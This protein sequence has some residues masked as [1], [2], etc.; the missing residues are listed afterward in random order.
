MVAG[1]LNFSI[2]AEG[3]QRGG[4]REAEPP[5]PPSEA[6]C[7]VTMVQARHV[8]WFTVVM[9]S[10]ATQTPGDLRDRRTLTR[11]KEAEKICP[12]LGIQC[13]A[14]SFLRGNSLQKRCCHIT[15]F[16]LWGVYEI[17]NKTHF[18][19][20]LN[21]LHPLGEYCIYYPW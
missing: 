2:V 1:Q 3:E 18:T 21:N 17:S 5:P 12:K 14:Y 10:S 6:P 19:R 9:S 20:F 16:I 15:V 4:V 7:S 8:I 11:S 13:V